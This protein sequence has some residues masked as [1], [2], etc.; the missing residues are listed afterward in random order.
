MIIVIQNETGTDLSLA[1][2]A[3]DRSAH[4]RV[5][6]QPPELAEDEALERLRAGESHGFVNC[7]E[8]LRVDIDVSGVPMAIRVAQR[9]EKVDRVDEDGKLDGE[10][11]YLEFILTLMN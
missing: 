2:S 1:I 9:L 5:A 8:T 11:T 7:P 10:E 4:F 3:D 6:L